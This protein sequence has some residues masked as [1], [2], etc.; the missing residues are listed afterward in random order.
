MYKKNKSLTEL[1]RAL[2]TRLSYFCTSEVSSFYSWV[3]LDCMAHLKVE[4]M[5]KEVHAYWEYIPSEFLYSLLLFLGPL[6]F[7]LSGPKL[8]LAQ[9]VEVAPRQL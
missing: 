1:L 4:K 8:S 2:L 9:T 7:S 3:S 6:Y 5:E